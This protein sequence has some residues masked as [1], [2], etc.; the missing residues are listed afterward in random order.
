MKHLTPESTMKDLAPIIPTIYTALDHGIFKTKEF[1]E[2]QERKDDRGI[3]RYL[4]PNVVRYY[5]IRHLIRAGQEAFEDNEL[6]L[7][8][9][10]NNGIHIN[11]DPYQIKILKS[12]CGGLPT[13]GHSIKR[14]EYYD[15]LFPGFPDIEEDLSIINLLLLWDIK[16]NYDGLRALSLA[17]PKSG[18]ETRDSVQHH[19]HCKIPTKLLYG[20]YSDTD[21]I[22]FEEILDLQFDN[23]HLDETGTENND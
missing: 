16:G 3:D 8:N 22:T 17:C 21:V 7:D 15:Q 13:P 5:A 23:V 1:F 14:Q 20:E 12:N 18:K 2:T 19:F 6:S 4:A 10:P 9:I 11:C